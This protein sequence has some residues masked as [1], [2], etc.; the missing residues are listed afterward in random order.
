MLYGMLLIV[1]KRFLVRISV[2]SLKMLVTRVLLYNQVW[3]I[4]NIYLVYLV[5]LDDLALLVADNDADVV[6]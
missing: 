6:D 3:G 1:N 2:P 5:L 4:F